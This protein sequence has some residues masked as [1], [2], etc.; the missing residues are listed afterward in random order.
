MNVIEISVEDSYTSKKVALV[1]KS[2]NKGTSGVGDKQ[3]PI[4]FSE[5]VII[6][7]VI[8]MEGI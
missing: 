6:E 3:A 8:H 5:S 2:K 7:N 4:D 1:V